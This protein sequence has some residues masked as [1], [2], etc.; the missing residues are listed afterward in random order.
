MPEQTFLHTLRSDS[1]ALLATLRYVGQGESSGRFELLDATD[2][3]ILVA[4][5]T[6]PGATRLF[7]G[8]G[9]EIA[10]AAH[11]GAGSC[12]ARPA[13]PAIQTLGSSTVMMSCQVGEHPA[14]IVDDYGNRS[15]HFIYGCT[16]D[17][18]LHVHVD[19][20]GTMTMTEKSREQATLRSIRRD[21]TGVLLADEATVQPGE[22]LDDVARRCGVATDVLVAANSSA[23]AV[24][25]PAPGTRVRL[26]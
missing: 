2:T 8:V 25:F 1:G 22:G 5:V 6:R 4:Q 15:R 11:S 13:D 23:V 10:L 12:G 18:F 26:N 19:A 3:L 14:W 21:A 20:G 7:D 16:P 17:L 24:G 9:R